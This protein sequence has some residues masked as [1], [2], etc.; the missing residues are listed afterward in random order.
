MNQNKTE[1]ELSSFC[2]YLLV[3]DY[4]R[5]RNVVHYICISNVDQLRANYVHFD[6]MLK[7]KTGLL[8]ECRGDG[9]DN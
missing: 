8:W 6:I 5:V 2:V 7:K 1:I 4:I 9:P 3:F